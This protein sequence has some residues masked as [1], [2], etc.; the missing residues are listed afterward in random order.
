MTPLIAYH[1]IIFIFLL[2]TVSIKFTG[3]SIGFTVRVLDGP[4]EN[5]IV[6]SLRVTDVAFVEYTGFHGEVTGTPQ[7]EK[8]VNDVF[9]KLNSA[10]EAAALLKVLMNDTILPHYDLKPL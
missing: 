9:T 7:I 2:Q 5:K 10:T 3:V 8:I 6:H 4:I 1:L